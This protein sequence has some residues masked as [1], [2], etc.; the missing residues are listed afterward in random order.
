MED[1]LISEETGLA[2]SHCLCCAIPLVEIA[3]SWLIYKEFVKGECVMEYAI[4]QPC[5]D[6]V[7]AKFSKASKNSV[8]DF[9]KREIDWEARIQEFM[10]SHRLTDRL[11]ACICCQTRREDLNGFSLSALM[12]SSGA[13]VVGP[14]PLL[15]CQ[16]CGNRMMNGLSAECREV[17]MKWVHEH[18]EGQPPEAGWSGGLI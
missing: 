6:Q 3:A 14:L 13:L 16:S 1:W 10:L 15:M 2:F 17:W 9:L 8:R 12:D 4:C 18:F 7:S 5:R 11:N